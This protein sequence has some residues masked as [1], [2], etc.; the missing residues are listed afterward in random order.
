ME[1]MVA[2]HAGFCFG[3]KKAI[4]IAEETAAKND[5]KTYVYG[6][7][8]H[9]EQVIEDLQKKGIEF[10]ENID[11]IPENAVT[12]LRDHG[13]PGTTYKKL[14]QKNIIKD[15]KLN[16][17]TCPLVNLVHNVAI[18]LKN[19]GYEVIIFGKK[20]H[21]ESIGTSYHI[22]G[23]DTFIVEDPG[24]ASYVVD[25]INKNNLNKV[26]LIS[27]TTMSVTGYKELIDN[28]NKISSTKFGELHL[29]M[30]DMDRSFVFVDTIC[31]PTKQRQSDTEE[32]AKK[33]DIMIVIGGKNSSNSKELA[34]KSEEF[35]VETYFI[36]SADQLQK[37]WFNKKEHI[38]VTAGASTPH[39]LIN[40]I[41]IRIQNM[42]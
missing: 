25:Y 27:Q 23:K 29:S 12:V 28:I 22:K 10:V 19:N 21:P 35:G 42:C 13:E 8:V 24:D 1:I 2:K 36:Q 39:S 20:D 16:D 5:G 34:S 41:V 32:I 30:K 31:N 4:E 37:D 33:A 38:G 7:L 15:G 3:V 40:E 11:D 26:A 17:A 18:K 6:Q 14:Q 9:N